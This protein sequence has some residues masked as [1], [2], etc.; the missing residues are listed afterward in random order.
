MA[1]RAAGPVSRCG[2]SH[3]GRGRMGALVDKRGEAALERASVAPGQ[4][5]G[6]GPENSSQRCHRRVRHQF[7]RHDSAPPSG[8]EFGLLRAFDDLTPCR[9]RAAI[10]PALKRARQCGLLHAG[11]AARR[12]GLSFSDTVGRSSDR[13]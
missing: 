1:T 3:P 9:L 12:R 7:W 5:R 10:N 11:E 8:D 13:R 2:K 6:E 4:C